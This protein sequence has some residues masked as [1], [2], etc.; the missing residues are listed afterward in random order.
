EADREDPIVMHV[1]DEEPPVVPA[2]TF[3]EDEPVGEHRGDERHRRQSDVSLKSVASCFWT[4]IRNSRLRMVP[5]DLS[6]RRGRCPDEMSAAAFITGA[7]P[8]YSIAAQEVPMPDAT[9]D[10]VKIHYNET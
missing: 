5:R 8:W 10:G 6:Q 4:A 3:E 9:I 1:G 7:S 2:W